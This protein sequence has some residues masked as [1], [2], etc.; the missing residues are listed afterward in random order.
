[1]GY[2]ARVSHNPTDRARE[3][4]LAILARRAV[5]EAELRARLVKK[6]HAEPDIDA[7]VARLR[8]LRYLDDAQ[9]AARVAD[10]A[11]ATGRGPDWV[12][13]KL[14]SRGVDDAIAGGATSRASLTEVLE[15]RFGPVHALGP[16]DRARA[17]R[18]LVARG[19]AEDDVTSALGEL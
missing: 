1:V 18:F 16:T 12:T 15:S 7:A 8:D 4:A 11:T 5:S 19:F 6:G 13:R 2:Q 9:L 17:Y 10:E 14:K 3:D